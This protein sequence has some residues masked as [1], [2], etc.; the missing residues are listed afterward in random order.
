MVS[1]GAMQAGKKKYL[2]VTLLVSYSRQ[3]N[4]SKIK[5][6]NVFQT[7]AFEPDLNTRARHQAK[8]LERVLC[9]D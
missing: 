8:K 6:E 5:I 2:S 1:P 7:S 4:S 9:T 3:K